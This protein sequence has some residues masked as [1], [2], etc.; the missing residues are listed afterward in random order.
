ML[1]D[2]YTSEWN[3]YFNF[4]YPSMKL[5][6]KQRIGSKIKKRY[7]GPKT[8]HQRLME[9]EHITVQTKN[10]LQRQFESLNPFEIQQRMYA[11]IKAIINI[12]SQK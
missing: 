11:K 6:E 12:V 8:P 5:I 10:E 2:L 1:N 4:F 7:D 3:C 9:S